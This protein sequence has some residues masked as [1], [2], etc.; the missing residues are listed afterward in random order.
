MDVSQEAKERMQYREKNKKKLAFTIIGGA[1]LL[2][3]VACAVALPLMYCKPTPDEKVIEINAT[4][5][6]N[7][8]IDANTQIYIEQSSSG[9][10][11]H[12]LLDLKK[13]SDDNDNITHFVITEN[14]DFG[15][16]VNPD[17]DCHLSAKNNAIV[18]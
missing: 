11:G 16:L 5:V 14:I 18:N 8:L 7:Y 15:F 17:M 13:L 4:N 12:K 6:T 1:I 9:A 10:F 2:G 3:G